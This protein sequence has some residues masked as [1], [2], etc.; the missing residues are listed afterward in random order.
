MTEINTSYLAAYLN[1]LEQTP[2][3][4]NSQLQSYI[5]KFIANLEVPKQEIE[6]DWDNAPLWANYACPTFN[7]WMY[8]KS[9]PSYQSV[10]SWGLDVKKREGLSVSVDDIV[11]DEVSLNQ[12]RI[13]AIGKMLLDSGSEPA[14]IFVDKTVKNSVQ[15]VMSYDAFVDKF[16]MVKRSNTSA[17]NS[18]SPIEQLITNSKNQ[19]SV[20]DPNLFRTLSLVIEDIAETSALWHVATLHQMQQPIEVINNIELTV[21][22]KKLGYTPI[23]DAPVSCNNFKERISSEIYSALDAKLVPIDCTNANIYDTIVTQSSLFENC[24]TA[25]LSVSSYEEIMQDSRVVYDDSITKWRVNDIVLI[26]DP[27]LTD[28]VV[29]LKNN[30]NAV[31]FGVYQLVLF[32]GVILSETTQEPQATILSRYALH[33]NDNANLHFTKLIF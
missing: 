17:A 15:F 13:S 31:L 7:E 25:I 6:L 12:Y 9:K 28:K 3:Y 27:T 20:H 29:Y 26:Q 1:L 21:T 14:I 32:G 11:A 16:K 2:S 5:N 18:L 8:F 23:D 19:L 22:T 4:N 30:N 24:N 33:I 10:T